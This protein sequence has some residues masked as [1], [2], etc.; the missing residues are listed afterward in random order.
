MIINQTTS[1]ISEYYVYK[2]S[3]FG[4]SEYD[5]NSYITNSN[6]KS[7]YNLS[8]SVSSVVAKGLNSFVTEAY[9]RIIYFNKGDLY[10]YAVVW[11]TE[12]DKYKCILYLADPYVGEFCEKY[13]TYIDKL[14]ENRN[15]LLLNLKS[16]TRNKVANADTPVNKK[17]DEKFTIDDYISFLNLNYSENESEYAPMIDKLNSIKESMDSLSKELKEL[18]ECE[19]IVYNSGIESEMI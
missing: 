18:L 7:F 11:N 15:N 16:Y 9:N 13:S 5:L 10:V 8:E 12:V 2:V 3:D 17:F 14:E 6:V 4:K 1:P 19:L